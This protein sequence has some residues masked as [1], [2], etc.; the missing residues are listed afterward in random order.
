M[1][2]CAI[3]RRSC[4]CC[5]SSGTAARPFRWKQK[6][7]SRAFYEANGFT[8][9]RFSDVSRNEARESDTECLWQGAYRDPM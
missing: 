3:A 7:R 8:A 2:R 5:A 6:S 4:G 1:H 9:A